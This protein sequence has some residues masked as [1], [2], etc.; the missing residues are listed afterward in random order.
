MNPITTCDL[1]ETALL[2]RYRHAGAYTDCFVLDIPRA[3]SQAAYVEAF[4]TTWLFKLER[5]LLS[6][7]M[8]RP[9]TDLEAAELALGRRDEFAAW[10]VEGRDNDQLLMCDFQERTRSWLMSVTARDG[11]GSR[12]YFGSAVVPVVDSSGQARMGLLFRALLGF[13]RFYSRAL[14][15]AAVSRLSNIGDEL[16]ST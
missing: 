7:F 5:R 9:S 11:H 4:Y 3:V 8:H 1:P 2:V 10:R 6:W 12:L 16:S 13:H 15:H 14:L